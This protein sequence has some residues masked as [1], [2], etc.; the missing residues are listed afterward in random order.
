MIGIIIK[1][2]NHTEIPQIDTLHANTWLNSDMAEIREAAQSWPPGLKSRV[3]DLL[4]LRQQPA[5]QHREGFLV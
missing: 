4:E 3:Q 5:K 2:R 1:T